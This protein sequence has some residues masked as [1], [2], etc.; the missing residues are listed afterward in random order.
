MQFVHASFESQFS[1]M[2]YLLSKIKLQFLKIY[3]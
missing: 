1:K 2:N 3:F